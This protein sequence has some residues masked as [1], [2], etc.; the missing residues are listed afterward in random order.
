[1]EIREFLSQLPLGAQVTIK[2]TALGCEEEVTGTYHGSTHPLVPK[3]LDGFA[4]PFK[5][6]RIIVRHPTT[7]ELVGLIPLPSITTCSSPDY[8]AVSPVSE[9]IRQAIQAEVV[10]FLN[11]FVSKGDTKKAEDG[12]P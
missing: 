4:Y 12:E 6:E 1:M 10:A 11:S 9:E 3:G 5:E 7:N 8:A 2:H